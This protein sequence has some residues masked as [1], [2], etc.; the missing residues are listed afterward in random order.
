[1]LMFSFYLRFC[2]CWNMEWAVMCCMGL[3]Q[4]NFGLSIRWK[5]L[6][7]KIQFICQK[8][9]PHYVDLIGLMSKISPKN[10]IWYMGFVGLFLVLWRIKSSQRVCHV[11][12]QS[13]PH[14]QIIFF[15][16]VFL[17]YVA[18]CIASHGTIFVTFFGFISD[19]KRA[20]QIS[21]IVTIVTKFVTKKLV[22]VTE[23]IL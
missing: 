17:S 2:M 4:F 13:S 23:Y 11:T 18:L 9:Q 8:K 3:V 15:C 5:K 14:Q 19:E 12:S 22:F 10:V 20:S 7:F 6:K 21:D 1:M 16:D